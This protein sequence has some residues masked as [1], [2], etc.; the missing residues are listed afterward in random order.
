[1]AIVTPPIRH[2]YDFVIFL[3]LFQSNLQYIR[4]VRAHYYCE[5]SVDHSKNWV[6]L[7]VLRKQ[8]TN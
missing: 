5:G 3:F 7:I 6:D 4:D 1:M 2:F 8:E